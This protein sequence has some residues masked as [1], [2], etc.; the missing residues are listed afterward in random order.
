MNVHLKLTHFIRKLECLDRG[1]YIYPAT[2]VKKARINK[3]SGQIFLKQTENA[4]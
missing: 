1:L 2:T 4:E 3:V